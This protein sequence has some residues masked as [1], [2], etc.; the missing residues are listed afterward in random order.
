[1]EDGKRKELSRVLGGLEA[2]KELDRLSE[3]DQMLQ[4]NRYAYRFQELKKAV[5][6]PTLREF[7]VDLDRKGHLTRLW[8]KSA[9]K[10][11]LDVQIQTR[12][13]KRGAIEFSLSKSDPSKLRVDYGWATGDARFHEEL[14][15]LERVE[16]GF[17]ADRILHLLKGLL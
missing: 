7:M 16:A 17:V 2:L 12:M 4:K 15:G 6:L 3:R 5:I 9:E 8:E 13:P 11:R 14:Y 1:L 10:V